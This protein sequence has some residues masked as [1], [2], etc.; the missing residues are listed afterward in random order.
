MKTTVKIS[1]LS[2]LLFSLVVPQMSFA[3]PVS[4]CV[5]GGILDDGYSGS[6][7]GSG[8]YFGTFTCSLYPSASPYTIN[9]TSYMTDNG[10]VNLYEGSI[11]SPVTAGYIVVINGDPNTL[12]DDNS[13]LWNQSLWAAVLFWPGDLNA[14]TASDS[15]TVYYA[16][17]SG[18]PTVGDVQT[19][20]DYFY[21]GGPGVDQYYFVQSG[22]PAVYLPYADEY[23][24]YPTP[25]PS[26]LL[27]L[28]SGLAGLAGVLRRKL[29]I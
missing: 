21:G 3:G 10:T 18:F 25:E 28:G 12:S 29:R 1:I 23:D 24:I 15:L 22:D 7:Y 2:A 14:G 16:G 19:F 27:L 4:G 6:L 20:N 8:D 26:S 5:Q 13:G 17:N 11:V 9:L